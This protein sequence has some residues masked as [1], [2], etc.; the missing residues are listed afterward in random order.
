MIEIVFIG[1]QNQ[2]N[3]IISE[4]LNA[5]FDAEATFYGLDEILGKSHL[6]KSTSVALIILDLNTTS[7]FD[8]APK[9]IKRLNRQFKDIP[10]LVIHPYDGEKLI[11]PLAEAGAHGIISITPPTGKLL[12]AVKALLNGERFISYPE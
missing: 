10:L 12:K 5:N 1:K 4:V 6:S 11:K 3:T 2:T 7:G 9:N 8:T